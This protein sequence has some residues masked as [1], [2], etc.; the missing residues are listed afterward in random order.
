MRNSLAKQRARAKAGSASN[1]VKTISG[2]LFCKNGKREKVENIRKSDRTMMEKRGA[3][4]DGV[5]APLFIDFGSML[6]PFWGQN[7]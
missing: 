3:K 7:L 1:T 6:V 5:R 4:K 2:G